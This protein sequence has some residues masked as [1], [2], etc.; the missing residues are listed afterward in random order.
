MP[1]PP[2]PLSSGHSRRLRSWFFRTSPGP[3]SWSATPPALASARYC[4]RTK[5]QSPSSVAPRHQALAAYEHELI[6]LVYAVRHWQPYL[7]GRPFIVKMDHASLKFF[8]DQRLPQHQA[9]P[10]SSSMRC[11]VATPG[12]LGPCGPAHLCATVFAVA[13]AHDGGHEGVQRTLQRFRRDFHTPAAR[14]IVED[15]VRYCLVCQRNKT[16]QLHPGGLLQPLPVP[17]AVWSVRCVHG[18]HG[19][20]SQGRRQVG[21]DDRG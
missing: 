19:G 17:T 1:R 18:L 20:T 7:W 10:M 5:A 6:R 21:H 11:L 3:S 14:C 9:A 2:L 12:A 15:Y 4:T 13:A 8:L 16:E